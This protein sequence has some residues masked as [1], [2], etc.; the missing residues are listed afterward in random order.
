MSRFARV[1]EDPDYED[2]FDELAEYNEAQGQ[3]V[4]EHLVRNIEEFSPHQTVNS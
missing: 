1:V 4:F 2:S 3:K